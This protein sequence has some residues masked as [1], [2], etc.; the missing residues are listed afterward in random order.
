MC[1][2]APKETIT[3]YMGSGKVAGYGLA[4][5]IAPFSTVCSRTM[6]PS[7]GGIL[8]AG[9]GKL[10]GER[11]LKRNTKQAVRVPQQPK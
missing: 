10:L 1:E 8:Y 3:K 7:F 9:A 2:F 5:G 6:V 11:P 4:L